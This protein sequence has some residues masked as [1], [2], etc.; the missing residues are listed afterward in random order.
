MIVS[1]LLKSC[2][3]PPVRLPSASI[4]CD[5]RSCA[6]TVRCSVTSW[7][8][9]SCLPV[10]LRRLAVRTQQRISASD[11]AG[12]D[13]GYQLID[14]KRTGVSPD[15]VF[16]NLTGDVQGG[17]SRNVVLERTGVTLP[18]QGAFEQMPIVPLTLEAG[19]TYVV[20]TFG[21]EGATDTVLELRRGNGAPNERDAT[22]AENDDAGGSLASRVRITA[23]EGGSYYARVRPYSPQAPQVSSAYDGCAALAPVCFPVS[24]QGPHRRSFRA[25]RPDQWFPAP[26]GRHCGSS[27]CLAGSAV[28]TCR[29]PSRRAPGA[30]HQAKQRRGLHGGHFF[31]QN[32]RNGIR[33]F[34]L[35]CVWDL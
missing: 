10:V 34:D 6:S 8:T 28:C 20:E 19:H 3:M 13:V 1:R 31:R 18:G 23:S 25:H 26:Q 12:R 7:P 16:V 29:P 32:G 2:A 21:L 35:S 17:V 9:E 24:R 14:I 5:W 27:R 11:P 22:V 15:M 30:F 33:V 4:F